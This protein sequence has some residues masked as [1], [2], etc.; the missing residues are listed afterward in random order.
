MGVSRWGRG[1]GVRPTT[2]IKKKIDK[3]K[4][5]KLLEVGLFSFTRGRI[6]FCTFLEK[7]WGRG[8]VGLYIIFYFI[9]SIFKYNL[10]SF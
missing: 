6:L 5:S 9:S 2:K 4:I 8:G 1:G 10:N 7:E 3:P